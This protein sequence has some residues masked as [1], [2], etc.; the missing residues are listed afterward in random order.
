MTRISSAAVNTQLV[1]RLLQTQ[2]RMFDLQA[3][4]NSEKKSQ[5]YAGISLDTQ[6]LLNIE[7]SRDRLQRYI[8][9]NEQQQTRLNVAATALDAA[10][11]SVRDF[12]QE[13]TN[14]SVGKPQIRENV[15]A[16]QSAAFRAL[17]D[18]EDLLNTEVD[19]RFL[20]SGS[21]ANTEPVDFNVPLHQFIPIHIR[22]CSGQSAG[23]P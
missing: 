17:R 2:E 10:R 8:R 15:D 4:V 13:L 6:R 23:N 14:Y 5:D 21:R 20:F 7:N 11:N 18:L 1:N 3:Q 12:R 9:N 16:V 22:W 19:G